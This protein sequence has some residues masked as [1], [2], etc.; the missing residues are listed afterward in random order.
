MLL[1]ILVLVLVFGGGG[2]FTVIAAGD[3][4]RERALDW[5]LYLLMFAWGS[6]TSEGLAMSRFLCSGFVTGT[7][8][9][10]VR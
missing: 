2:G 1:V 4:A 3:M 10:H 7:V 5:G 9:R 8:Q 6:S